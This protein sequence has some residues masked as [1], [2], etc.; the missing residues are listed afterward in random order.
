MGNDF[1]RSVV[2]DDKTPAADGVEQYD[3][4]VG[5]LSH[6]TLTIK[7]LN[8]TDE[9]T[10]QNI[11]AL[12]PKIEVLHRGSSIYSI[13]AVDLFALNAIL[14]GSLPYALNLIA[15]DNAT[16]AVTLI[17]PFGR[18]LY[19]PEECFPDTKSGEL[20]LSLTVDIATAEADGLIILAESTELVNAR[21]ARYLKVTTLN[22]TPSATGE[23]DVDLPIQAEQAGILLWGTTVAATTAWTATIDKVKLLRDNKEFMVSS[24]KW[25]A[26]QDS[27]SYRLGHQP[28]HIAAS[29][30][31]EL[32]HHGF[33]DFT[34][35]NQD[36]YLVDTRGMSSW[37]L[38]IT[39][40]DTNAGRVLPLELLPASE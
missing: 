7:C 20:V 19:N 25:E 27:I 12:V 17:I 10:V 39:A 9:A 29:G 40:G 1:I 36:A 34:Y 37:V 31:P 38:R 24:S 23:M 5:P 8:V 13:S 33:L 21:P 11:L 18:G 4:P 14:Y 2:V 35:L 32:A 16:R 6:I 3:L 26:L 15:T 30:D 28:G 22:F